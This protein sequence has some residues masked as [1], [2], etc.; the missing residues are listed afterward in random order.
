[1]QQKERKGLNDKDA[2]V[3]HV[4]LKHVDIK[5]SPTSPFSC[6]PGPS[7]MLSVAHE[8]FKRF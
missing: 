5:E 4:C 3:Q 7:A 1:M 6:Q 2:R 8:R